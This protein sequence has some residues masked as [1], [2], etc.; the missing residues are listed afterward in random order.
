MKQHIH[1]LGVCGTFMGSL[2]Q[3]AKAAGYRVTGCDTGVYP[4]MS[5]QLENAGIE[6]IEGFDAQQIDLNPD[7]FVVGNVVSRGNA[8]MEAILDRGLPFISGP[9]WLSENILQGKW[10]LGVS[11][12]HG[13]TTT[14]SMLAWVLEFAGFEP[15]FLIGG[16]PEN[17]GVSARLGKSDFFVVEADEYDT[18]FF[19]KRSKFVHYRPHTLIVN[20]LEYDH[21][22]IF[23]D[24]AAIQTQFHHL[25]RTVPQSGCIFRPQKHVALDELWDMGCWSETQTIEGSPEGGNECDWSFRLSQ[26]DQ[27]E[28]DVIFRGEVVG[29]VRWQ[30]NGIHNIQNALN[31]VAAARHIGI[32]PEVSAAAL[33]EFQSVKRRFE[34]IGSA[35][36]VDIYDDFAHHPTAIDTTLQGVQ[37]RNHTK[38]PVVV[39]IEP[40][41]NTMKMGCHRD[42]LRASVSRADQVYWFEAGGLDWS[43]EKYVSRA[44]G[45]SRVFSDTTRLIQAVVSEVPENAIIVVMSNGGFSGMPRS[46]L[47]AFERSEK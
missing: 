12:T 39:V 47:S 13:K 40:R 46:L 7:V 8:L 37:A 27:S 43:L 41:S 16:V 36:G 2:A 38:R 44:D 45:S 21:A 30:L 9:Q 34:W 24:L 11:G 3:L 26:E 18:A 10:V 5:T 35:S 31:A 4:P 17:F 32:A 6:L 23:P 14:S 15:G 22:D 1:I 20:N 19:D 42:T 25:I 28:F 29:T 33:N